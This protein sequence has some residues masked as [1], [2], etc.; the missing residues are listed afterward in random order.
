MIRRYYFI[1]SG[2]AGTDSIMLLAIFSAVCITAPSLRSPR[3][4][5]VSAE[6]GLLGSASECRLVRR[7]DTLTGP[8]DCCDSCRSGMLLESTVVRI[9][10]KWSETSVHEKTLASAA[11][12]EVKNS[13][14]NDASGASSKSW[15]ESVASKS[16]KTATS[17]GNGADGSEVELQDERIKKRPSGGVATAADEPAMPRP[18]PKLS[19]EADPDFDVELFRSSAV[20]S[21]G[22]SQREFANTDIVDTIVC[23]VCVSPSAC[24]DNGKRI[25]TWHR[26]CY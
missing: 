15:S 10:F 21:L 18:I 22:A 26:M 1:Y 16:A 12:V 23:N 3:Q 6:Y 13:V 9:D 24:L 11:A 4:S 25:N 20:D 17:S 14:T 19:P 7:V 5:P 2:Q 8:M